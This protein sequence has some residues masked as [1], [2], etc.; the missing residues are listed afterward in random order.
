MLSL[1]SISLTR[2]ATI[3]LANRLTESLSISSSSV[4]VSSDVTA[5]E[6]RRGRETEKSLVFLVGMEDAARNARATFFVVNMTA[7]RQ[8][9]TESFG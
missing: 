9:R 7:R 1:S 6:E 8:M 4:R 3:S 2:G 5:G